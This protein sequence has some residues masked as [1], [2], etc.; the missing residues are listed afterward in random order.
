MTQPRGS[1]PIPAD[2]YVG[3]MPI[4]ADGDG[5]GSHLPPFIAKCA[6]PAHP[7][8]ST[9]MFFKKVSKPAEVELLPPSPAITKNVPWNDTAKSS[10]VPAVTPVTAVAAKAN[11]RHTRFMPWITPNFSIMAPHPYGPFEGSEKRVC[12]DAAVPGDLS[13]WIQ[14]FKAC[15]IVPALPPVS[16]ERDESGEPN[17]VTLRKRLIHH[18]SI[19]VDGEW[20]T[21]TR[22]AYYGVVLRLAPAVTA[23]SP[24]AQD[25]SL[26]YD[27]NSEDEWS[28]EEHGES[29]NTCDE[30]EEVAGDYDLDDAFIDN[31]FDAGKILPAANLVPQIMINSESIDASLSI[32]FA[33][34][35]TE[36]FECDSL[37]R[38]AEQDEDKET[39]GSKRAHRKEWDDQ[40]PKVGPKKSLA[41]EAKVN[42]NQ[43]ITKYV[44]KY[45]E[46]EHRQ[47]VHLEFE[48]LS[49][50]NKTT[51]DANASQSVVQ[52]P[53]PQLHQQ[54]FISAGTHVNNSRDLSK[55]LQKQPQ[56]HQKP[57]VGPKKSLAIEAKVNP[58]QAITKYVKKYSET[59]HRQKVHL[60]F[61]QLSAR[62]KTTADANASQSVVQSPLPQPSK[63]RSSKSKTKKM[64]YAKSCGFGESGAKPIVMFNERKAVGGHN[65]LKPSSKTPDAGAKRKRA[66]TR[67]KDTSSSF[68][69][70]KGPS[71]RER[72]ELFFVGSP[73]H[74]Q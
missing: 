47:K 62:N 39:A 52:S 16:V 25:K 50:R 34:L 40:K 12:R 5:A 61:E 10:A 46:T 42:P 41:I 65:P 1:M 69:A 64:A 26:D 44:K 13:S 45:S 17:G 73:R 29:I 19:M 63:S 56:H 36:W 54:P 43:A 11:A 14:V 22:P 27:Y 70:L 15:K 67:Q 2:G 23:R 30:D 59:E 18:A 28:E 68:T 53:L 66:Q 33:E 9:A 6:P 72:F 35:A 8:K 74:R 58:N 51:A 7:S 21:A 38:D 20:F 24:L 31:E 60:E 49:A 71:A 48:Q 37:Q 3:S 4:P 55:Q 57:K 32:F